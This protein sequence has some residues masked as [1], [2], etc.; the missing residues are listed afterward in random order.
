MSLLDDLNEQAVKVREE[1]IQEICNFFLNY[2]RPGFVFWKP[3]SQDSTYYYQCDIVD[4][5]MN[6]LPIFKTMTFSYVIFTGEKIIV[7]SNDYPIKIINYNEEE[8]PVY[9]KNLKDQNGNPL[10]FYFVNCEY[11]KGSSRSE[12]LDDSPQA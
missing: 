2:G 5:Y 3:T 1:H 7:S 8:L 9:I 11:L 6:G 4:G 12:D 10:W